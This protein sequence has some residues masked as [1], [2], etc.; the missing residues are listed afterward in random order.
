M[1]PYIPTEVSLNVFAWF[2]IKVDVFSGS[3]VMQ[4]VRCDT[5]QS[6]WTKA[7]RSQLN[8]DVTDNVKRMRLCLLRPCAAALCGRYRRHISFVIMSKP[9]KLYSVH[10][11]RRFQVSA[12]FFFHLNVDLNTA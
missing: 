5:Q 9:T 8:P 6:A 12:M 4:C 11:S 1:L 3:A 7:K 10:G 2:L